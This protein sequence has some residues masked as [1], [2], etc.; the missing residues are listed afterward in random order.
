MKN[1]KNYQEYL[2]NEGNFD[3]DSQKRITKIK[4]KKIKFDDAQAKNVLLY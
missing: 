3:V 4:F 2:F 1:R